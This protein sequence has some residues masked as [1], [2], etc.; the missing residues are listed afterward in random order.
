VCTPP[1]HA[2]AAP[3]IMHARTNTHP[4]ASIPA[5]ARPLCWGGIRTRTHQPLPQQQRLR[6]CSKQQQAAASSSNV[7]MGGPA[8]CTM[9]LRPLQLATHPITHPIPHTHTHSRPPAPPGVM[10]G[11]TRTPR[12]SARLSAAAAAPPPSPGQQQ[13]QPAVDE[14]QG[15][16][17]V[18]TDLVPDVLAF[19]YDCLPSKEDRRSL[20]HSCRAIH[21][22]TQ[23]RAKVGAGGK[24][25]ILC[26]RL[27]CC[28]EIQGHAPHAAAPSASHD[29]LLSLRAAG[30]QDHTAQGWA[31][32]GTQL[33]SKVRCGHHPEAV[34]LASGHVTLTSTLPLH[35]HSWA[36]LDELVVERLSDEET[37]K[38]QQLGAS[39]RERLLMAGV[40]FLVGG[41]T[42]VLT[43]VES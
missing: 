40:R 6:A 33:I 23:L 20:L 11:N 38:L 25:L 1:H 12:R 5:H 42:V 32:G 7:L 13:Q 18:L 31:P 30:T 8:Q 9:E 29:C 41:A 2:W 19:V 16:G 15:D 22:L 10:Q 3:T 28:A 4:C 17:L 24:C 35:T 26:A 39:C 34:S 21:S 27:G 37:R 36:Q 43:D 14:E